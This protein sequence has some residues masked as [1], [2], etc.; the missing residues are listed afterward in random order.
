[1][2]QSY[3]KRYFYST[4]MNN[5]A[6]TTAW[7]TWHAFHSFCLSG[8]RSR[9][10]LLDLQPKGRFGRVRCSFSRKVFYWCQTGLLL[11]C[12]GWREFCHWRRWISLSPCLPPPIIC[13][14]YNTGS[15][16]LFQKVT[17][18]KATNSKQVHIL[19]VNLE[20]LYISLVA[21]NML[22]KSE[23]FAVPAKVPIT[24]FFLKDN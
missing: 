1:M 6:I 4:N 7:S 9:W 5:R 24:L 22:I 8:N 10:T 15:L 12:G 18:F 2:I 19:R 13:L 17:S 3:L 20:Q 16:C 11:G 23:F 14:K 21:F